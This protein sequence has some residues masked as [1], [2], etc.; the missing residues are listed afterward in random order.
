LLDIIIDLIIALFALWLVAASVRD[1]LGWALGKSKASTKTLAKAK[2]DGYAQGFKEG[3]TI[4]E[5]EG[6][7][8][9]RAFQ[10]A[11][12]AP[13]YKPQP[14]PLEQ[15]LLLDI[16]KLTHPD[17]HPPERAALANS[18]TQRVNVLRG[19]R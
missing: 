2:S 14:N 9:G 15:A 16:L 6:W 19:K 8:K 7:V 11:N 1:V 13:L 4:G 10:Q 3:R 17:K 5:T 18:V 12:S